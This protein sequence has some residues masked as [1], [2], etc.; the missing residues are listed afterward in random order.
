MSFT[1]RL[2]LLRKGKLTSIVEETGCQIRETFL[3]YLSKNTDRPKHV[4][5]APVFGVIVYISTIFMFCSREHGDNVTIINAT[6][7]RARTD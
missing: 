7:H 6:N 4:A 2:L 5:F 3:K 1:L